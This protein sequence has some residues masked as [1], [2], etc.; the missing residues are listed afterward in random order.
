MR[1]IIVLIFGVLWF[2]L[3]KILDS[4]IQFIFVIVM[5]IMSV[6]PS[7]LDKTQWKKLYVSSLVIRSISAFLLCVLV[8]HMISKNV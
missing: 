7:E 6:V 1:L 4:P 3:F 8:F 2:C 5:R